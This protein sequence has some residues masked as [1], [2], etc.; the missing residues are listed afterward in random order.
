MLKRI[1]LLRTYYPHWGKYSG[2]NRFIEYTNSD[3]YQ[4]DTQ[5]VP[6]GHSN[7]PIS[8]IR[9]RRRVERWIKKNGVKAYDLNDLMA[10]IKGFRKWWQ[11]CVDILHYLDGEHSLQ[12]LPSLIHKLGFKKSKTPVLATFHQPPAELV[13]LIN[14]DIIRNLD[15]VTVLCP[16]QKTYF[17]Q[18]FPQDKISLIHHGI[19]TDYFQPTT[20]SKQQNKFKCLTVGSWMRDYDTVMAVAK[21][22]EAYSDIEFHLV[23][24]QVE[25]TD[26]YGNVYLHQNIDDDALLRL[27]QHSDVLFLPLFGAT[28][29]NALLEGVACGLPVVSTQLPSIQTYVPGD[30]AILIKDNNPDIFAEALLNLYRQPERC[31]KMS[32]LACQRAMELSW[33][34]ITRQYEALYSQLVA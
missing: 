7:F 20:E 21:K 19:D 2:I 17:E 6:M 3:Q 24:S 23:S 30:E 10:E 22:L 14:P 18:F 13:S 28:A 5:V 12:Y 27:Y 34:K 33:T 29:N 16:E 32:E 11:G 9:I 8:N 26:E 15:H 31:R 4:I 25:V 1:H